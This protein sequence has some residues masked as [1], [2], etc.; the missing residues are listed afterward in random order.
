MGSAFDYLNGLT[1]S[2]QTTQLKRIADALEIIAG[3]KKIEEAVKEK[4]TV[5]LIEVSE[6]DIYNEERAANVENA[7]SKMQK[8]ELNSLWVEDNLSADELESIE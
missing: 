2:R 3:I 8:N 7:N 6:E 5:S 1:L 4:A